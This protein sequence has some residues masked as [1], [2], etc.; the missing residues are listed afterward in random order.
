MKSYTNRIVSEV[1]GLNKPFC[2]E[3]VMRYVYLTMQNKQVTL[4]RD[5]LV[6]PEVLK[7][8]RRHFAIFGLG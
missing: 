8:L 6:E 1:V 2:T 4:A 3:C 7:Q 5:Q